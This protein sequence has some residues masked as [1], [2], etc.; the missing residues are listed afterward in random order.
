MCKFMACMKMVNGNFVLYN[1]IRRKCFCKLQQAKN[2][3]AS[4]VSISLELSEW[5]ELCKKPRS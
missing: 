2:K 5:S 1:H 3:V 4:Q